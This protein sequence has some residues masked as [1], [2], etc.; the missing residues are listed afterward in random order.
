MAITQRSARYRRKLASERGLRRVEVVV[1]AD[2]ADDLKSYAARLRDLDLRRRRPDA[3][4][5]NDRAKLL[6]HRLVARRLRQ[7]PGLLIDARQRLDRLAGD[8][9][10]EWETLLRQ[11]LDRVCAVIIGRSSEAYRLRL[12]SPFRFVPELSITD[13]PLRRRLW[14]LARR[15]FEA[16]KTS[17]APSD[18]SRVTSRP[19][20]S[21]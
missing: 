6:H 12:S 1:P 2:M 17:T 5:V 10:R 14:R 9:L 16:S 13:E 21:S 15:P 19:T 4:A 18:R 11:P 20:R 7:R 3:E 8:D